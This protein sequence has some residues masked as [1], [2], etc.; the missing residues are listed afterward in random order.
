MSEPRPKRVFRFY[1]TK[2]G[3]YQITPFPEEP[4]QGDTDLEVRMRH[5]T[6]IENFGFLGYT[7]ARDIGAEDLADQLLDTCIN[8]EHFVASTNNLMVPGQ[9]LKISDA[10]LQAKIDALDEASEA[11]VASINALSAAQ[12]KISLG[13]QHEMQER[14]EGE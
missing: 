8:W 4:P 12:P 3:A 9:P 11:L 7:L 14:Q 2:L 13:L 6:E 1:D 5:F 10:A